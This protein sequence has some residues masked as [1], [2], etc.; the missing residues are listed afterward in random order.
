ME[1]TEPPA[2]CDWSPQEVRPYEDWGVAM[3][4]PSTKNQTVSKSQRMSR[5]GGRAPYTLEVWPDWY[6]DFGFLA[7]R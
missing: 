5:E 1:A 4:E 7:S 6:F 2:G 3:L